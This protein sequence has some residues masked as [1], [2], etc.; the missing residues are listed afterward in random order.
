M[1][2]SCTRVWPPAQKYSVVDA[3]CTDGAPA[4]CHPR[5]Q[6]KETQQRATPA[7]LKLPLRMGWTIT[8]L[9]LPAH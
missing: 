1:I 8:R 5:C 2:A 4:V 7:L 9:R 3:G 6:R